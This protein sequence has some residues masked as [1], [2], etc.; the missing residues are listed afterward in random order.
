VSY[1]IAIAHTRLQDDN[2]RSKIK[3]QHTL[4]VSVLFGFWYAHCPVCDA[5]F[6]TMDEARYHCIGTDIRKIRSR[7]AANA[8]QNARRA[9]MKANGI[10]R[11][12]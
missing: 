5:G 7:R 1:R 4:R 11:K 9:A 2:E 3:Q 8:R 12:A 10:K 6:E